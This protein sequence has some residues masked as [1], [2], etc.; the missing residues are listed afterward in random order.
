[1]AAPP[2][3][4]VENH[5]LGQCSEEEDFN[6]RREDLRVRFRYHG[7]DGSWRKPAVHH[8]R[9]AEDPAAGDPVRTLRSRGP[10]R[11]ACRGDC[12]ASTM[13]E[14]ARMAGK[15]STFGRR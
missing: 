4:A 2:F 1:M 12:G 8:V 10:E 13:S 5:R 11:A 3:W 14:C 6:E 7:R 9:R 15:I